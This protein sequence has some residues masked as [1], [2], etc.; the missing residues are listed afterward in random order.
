MIWCYPV[1]NGKKERHYFFEDWFEV[2]ITV[3]V[4]WQEKAK[5]Y[6]ALA[7]KANK[8]HQK[9]V[10]L[11][12]RISVHS[13]K[14]ETK[15]ANNLRARVKNITSK[16]KPVLDKQ[17]ALMFEM[18]SLF[19]SI[20]E[21]ALI[22]FSQEKTYLPFG[23]E[24]KE[25]NY[26]KV[27]L[28]DNHFEAYRNRHY[29]LVNQPLPTESIKEFEFQ[30]RTD[31]EIEALEGEYEKL[32]FFGK[33]TSSGRE[34]KARIKEAKSSTY[35]I[36]DLW[37]QSTLANKHFQERANQII[38]QIKED[39][40][41]NLPFLVALITTESNQDSEALEEIKKSSSGAY[42]ERYEAEFIKIF[43]Y[44]L[45]VFTK[46]QKK[47]SIATVKGIANFFLSSLKI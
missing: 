34:L 23:L 40:F 24:D 25:E 4:L 12:K 26:I 8:Y 21:E 46:Q 9:I 41:E 28:T 32:S 36:K 45:E 2:P 27:D 17:E 3:F 19:T 16:A 33:R 44:R 47:L 43:K 1:I 20:P 6:E 10:D 39:N 31:S 11:A 5:E 42:I 37:L 13:Y 15:A 35:K 18:I 14:G 7:E 22:S 38:D 29:L 30:S